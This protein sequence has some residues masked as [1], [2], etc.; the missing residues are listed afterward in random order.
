[1]REAQLTVKAKGVNKYCSFRKYELLESTS[2]VHTPLHFED[3]TVQHIPSIECKVNAGDAI[4]VPSYW[5]H[6]VT[7][8][9][10]PKQKFNK[11]SSIQLNAAVNFWF[12]PLYTKEFPCVTCLRQLNKAYIERVSDIFNSEKS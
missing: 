4:F 9:P 1:M 5:W 11:R 10:G 7:S 8:S 2:M 6:E 3:E 12:E